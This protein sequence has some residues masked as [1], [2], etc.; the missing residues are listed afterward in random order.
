MDYS[1]N[2]IVRIRQIEGAEIIDTLNCAAISER[3]FNRSRAWFTQ[4]LN[5]NLV[6]GKP[7]SFTPEELLKLRT[8]L[9]VLAS[10]ITRFTSKIPNIPTDM[11]IKVYV[12][13]DPTLIDFIR[14]SDI[15]GFRTYLNESKEED[16]FILFGEPEL[17]DTEA[18]AIAFCSGTGYGSDE[19]GPIERYPLCSCEECD[20]P[21]IEAIENY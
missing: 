1:D 20:L 3:F 13:D 7:A 6:N 5:N 16:N 8:S 2:N 11:A 18:E 12:V 21:F 9:K 19:R 10:E 17:F 14:E 15:E 4:R